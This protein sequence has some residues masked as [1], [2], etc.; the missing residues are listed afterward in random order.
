MN[1]KKLWKFFEEE[2][3]EYKNPN[4]FNQYSEIN[5]DFEEKKRNRNKEK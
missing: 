1:K 4:F 2:L 5:P 3:F